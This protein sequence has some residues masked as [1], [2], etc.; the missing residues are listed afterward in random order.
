MSIKT[1]R[2]NKEEE[3]LLQKILDYYGTDFSSCVK[4]LF[5]EKFED[6]IDLGWIKKFKEGRPADYLSASDIDALY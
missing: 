6:L 2:F 3:L 4:A 1:V 5:R